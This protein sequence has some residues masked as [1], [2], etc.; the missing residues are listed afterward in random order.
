MS[1]NKPAYN[2]MRLGFEINLYV[3]NR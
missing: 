1:W 2:E 3:S